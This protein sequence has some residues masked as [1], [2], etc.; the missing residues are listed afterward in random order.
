MG[1]WVP[2]PVTSK[3]ARPSIK[4]TSSRPGWARTK[5]FVPRSVMRSTVCNH[6][7]WMRRI[8]LDIEKRFALDELDGP[9]IGTEP[10]LQ[11]GRRIELDLRTVGQRD[12]FVRPIPVE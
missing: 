9:A 11:C 5:N 1:A 6:G 4:E 8:V 12:D 2:L 7:K 10:R 3:A